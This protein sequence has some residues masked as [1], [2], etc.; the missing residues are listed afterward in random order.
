MHFQFRLP[1]PKWTHSHFET[2]ASE[3]TSSMIKSIK[4]IPTRVPYRISILPWPS[5]DQWISHTHT[6]TMFTL[7]FDL[8]SIY[9]PEMGSQG[10]NM[11]F[12]AKEDYAFELVT[13]GHYCS[14]QCLNVWDIGTKSNH[15]ESIYWSPYS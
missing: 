8:W 13:T 6:M 5:E 3:D 9:S 7:F 2:N 4:L 10:A 1:S 15:A 11:E 14:S 12:G